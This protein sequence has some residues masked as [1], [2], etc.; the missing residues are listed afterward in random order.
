M[1]DLE[2][3]QLGNYSL[4]RKI[5]EGAFA[6]VYVGEHV[7]LNTLAAIKVCSTSVRCASIS[8][9]ESSRITVIY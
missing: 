9:G 2:G 7:R 6:E 8:A 4:T 3:Q 1:S 5:G